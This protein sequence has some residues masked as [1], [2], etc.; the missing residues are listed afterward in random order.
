LKGR[1]GKTHTMRQTGCV[2]IYSNQEW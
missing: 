2:T 1:L